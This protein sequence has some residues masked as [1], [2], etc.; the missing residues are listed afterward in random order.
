[1]GKDKEEN[2][3]TNQEQKIVPILGIRHKWFDIALKLYS[4]VFFAYSFLVIREEFGKGNPILETTEAIFVHLAAFSVVETI[5]FVALFQG[6][7]ILMYLTERFRAKLRRQIEEARIEGKAEG[8]V[9]GRAE[10]KAEV[11]QEMAAWNKRWLEAKAKGIP[12]D[13]QPPINSQE[14]PE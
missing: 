1:M 3:K 10:G 7:D 11:Y 2:T 14:K 5:I 4:V 6:V 12:F 9:E 13:E 8:K